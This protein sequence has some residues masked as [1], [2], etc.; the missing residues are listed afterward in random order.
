MSKWQWA[1][2][3]LL[4][5]LLVLGLGMVLVTA[6][7]GHVLNVLAQ[8]APLGLIASALALS[9]RAGVPNLAVGAVATLSGV[10]VATMAE[11]SGMSLGAALAS[12]LV[13][14]AVAGLVVGAFTVLVSEPATASRGAGGWAGASP[15]PERGNRLTLQEP[16]GGFAAPGRAGGA[17]GQTSGGAPGQTSGGALGRA[18]GVAG[19][20]QAFPMSMPAWAVTLG[21]GLACDAVSLAITGGR[22]VPVTQP[23]SPPQ[24]TWF[25]VFAVISMAGGAFWAALNV[26]ERLSDAADA[27]ARRM[28]LAGTVGMAGSAVL[29]ALGGFV[30]LVRL[31]AAQPGAQGTS[32]VVFALAAVL[33]GGTS[34]DGSRS[35]VTGTLLAVLILAIVQGQ[36]AL[37]NASVWVFYVILAVVVMAGLVVGRLLDALQ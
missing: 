37:L 11:A 25:V 15:L 2:E 5:V 23:P 24:V 3:G 7:T 14:A 31:G 8:A 29:A 20:S 17:P 27:G 35:A 1:W 28:W 32:T 6:P 4:G 21:A 30:L 9:F 16:A 12:V 19:R 13:V 22:T 34:P 18:G 33:L 36:L 10:L 26:R